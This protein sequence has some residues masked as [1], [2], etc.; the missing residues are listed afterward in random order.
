MYPARPSCSQQPAALAPSPLRHCS[1]PPCISRLTRC[2]LRPAQVNQHLLAVACSDP[3]VRLYDRRMLSPTSPSSAAAVPL[4]ELA[5]P[6]LQLGV[7]HDGRPK[8]S[9]TTCVSFGSTGRR[10]LANYNGDHAYCWDVAAA[11]S[12]SGSSGM[13]MRRM[14]AAAGCSSGDA[15][16]VGRGGRERGGGRVQQGAEQQE[17]QQQ[18]QQQHLSEAAGDLL[19]CAHIAMEDGALSQALQ[20]L[21]DALKLAPGGCGVQDTPVPLC[22]LPACRLAHSPALQLPVPATI[23]SAAC[24]TMSR[25]P[26]M[27]AHCHGTKHASTLR[28]QAMPQAARSTP[29]QCCPP[30]LPACLPA[31]NAE[32]LLERADVLMQRGWEGDVMLALR[33][34]DEAIAVGPG[35]CGAHFK[36]LQVR[37]TL[38][39]ARW[40]RQ[41]H[42]VGHAASA[43]TTLHHMSIR[44]T[45]CGLPAM[46]CYAAPSPPSP[47][48]ATHLLHAPSAI[49]HPTP[50]HSHPHPPPT[51]LLQIFQA[52][53]QLQTAAA[54]CEHY[55]RLFPEQA[56]LPP[57]WQLRHAVD[58]QLAARRE[59]LATQAE[60]DRLMRSRL[61]AAQQRHGAAAADHRQREGRQ[62]AGQGQ[63]AQQAQQAQQQGQ[64]AGGDGAGTGA[65]A[66]E[67]AAPAQAATGSGSAAE[68][69]AAGAAAGAPAAAGQAAGASTQP[70]AGA[71]AAE[72]PAAVAGSGSNAS[73][74]SSGS[75]SAGGLSSSRSDGHVSQDADLDSE[76]GSEDD[77]DSS[78]SGDD[79]MTPRSDGSDEE[80]ETLPQRAARRDALLAEFYFPS[81]GAPAAAPAAAAALAGPSDAEAA[82]AAA[83]G[84]NSGAAAAASSGRLVSTAVASQACMLGTLP[85]PCSCSS[86]LPQDTG[87]AGR[88]RGRKRPASPATQHLTGST[89]RT[90][91]QLFS[92]NSTAAAQAQAGSGP[93]GG[94]DGVRDAA[95][96]ATW[97]SS[98]AGAGS[99]GRDD[100]AGAGA[101][102][103]FDGVGSGRHGGRYSSSGSASGYYCSTPGGAA[104][105][106]RYVGHC[107]MQ[108]DIKEATFL[109]GADALVAAGSDDGRVFVYCSETGRLLRVLAADEDVANCVV[110]HPSAPVLATSGIEDVVRLW[111]PYGDAQRVSEVAVAEGDMERVVEG[112]MARLREGAGGGGRLLLGGLAG[113]RAMA[114]PAF[115]DLLVRGVRGEGGGVEDGS[116]DDGSDGEQEGEGADRRDAGCRMA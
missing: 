109:G 11:C 116:D 57:F 102:D 60:Q 47:P 21:N 75:S 25:L 27:Q 86:C 51:H 71:P 4:L 77:N 3:Y 104:L 72:A 15:D 50:P 88:S 92:L 28:R 111:Q 110:G 40:R 35:E 58:K 78:S 20:L 105:V 67:A 62:G 100:G 66:A 17:V 43:A 99:S 31:G 16:S 30:P 69:A 79:M 87:E 112:N 56:K 61:A 34:C 106:Q 107:N 22:C 14:G 1:A 108:T 89:A 13:Q 93:P 64:A 41:Q 84:S 95:E 12:S 98:H 9:H 8:T 49:S 5:P 81:A 82:D 23:S 55:V 59:R 24:L 113:L 33:D 18:Q 114:G 73:S 80:G 26:S 29:A 52:L 7:W 19:H 2:H 38:L 48:L 6:H 76:D 39:G 115:W 90:G 65:G 45:F 94:S 101:A 74:S 103:R 83:A 68:A 70:Q 63:Q 96:F 36:R 46:L 91:G 97:R 32:L 53:D 54:G 44:H 10:L 85:G 37:G 42:A